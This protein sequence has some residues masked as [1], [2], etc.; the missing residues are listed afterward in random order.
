MNHISIGMSL[1]STFKAYSLQPVLINQRC[2]EYEWIRVSK[3][4]ILLYSKLYYISYIQNFISA[5]K[6][7]KNNSLPI[8]SMY[9]QYGWCKWLGC[10][11]DYR[12]VMI[13]E[14]GR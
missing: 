1:M 11:S 9:T 4:S 2:S 5:H 14:V 13:I 6:Q 12:V 7:R 8:S 10:N 3:I